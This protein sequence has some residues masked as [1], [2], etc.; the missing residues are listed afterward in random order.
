MGRGGGGGW[1]GGGHRTTLGIERREVP[2]LLSKMQKFRA[3]LRAE[4]DPLLSACLS[5]S[6]RKAKNKK[7]RKSNDEDLAARG[8]QLHF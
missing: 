1:V 8:V 4:I 6:K 7:K 2:M 5:F 3:V